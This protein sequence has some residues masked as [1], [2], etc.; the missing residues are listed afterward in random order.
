LDDRL[1]RN[2]FSPE[3]LEVESFYANVGFVKNG[4]IEQIQKDMIRG[5]PSKSVPSFDELDVLSPQIR[6]EAIVSYSYLNTDI[7]FKYPFYTNENAFGFNDSNGKRAEVTSFCDYAKGEDSNKK[8]VREQVDILYYRYADESSAAEFAVDLCKHT[9]PYQVVLAR[10]P[11][12]QTL[13]ETLG[14]VQ[15]YISDFEKDPNYTVLNKLRAIDSLIVPD[16]LYKLTHRFK[17]LEGKKIVNPRLRALGYFIFEALQMVDFRLSR[18]GVVL[19]SEARLIAAPFA[20]RPR[21]I[22]E[23]R[24]FHFDRPFLIYV[25]KRGAEYSP[26]FVMWVDNAELMDKYERSTR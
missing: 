11:R 23:P 18:T 25:K 3:N 10:V 19:K 17:E 12:R 5:F 21:R 15:K 20:H 14:E 8:Y 16:V 6:K 2:E 13:S 7:G 26:F 1:N 24:H 9:D 22:E 4:I